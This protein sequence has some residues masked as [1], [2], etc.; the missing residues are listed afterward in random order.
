MS[1][2]HGLNTGPRRFWRA[3]V[4]PKEGDLSEWRKWVIAVV[5]GNYFPAALTILLVALRIGVAGMCAASMAS[6]SLAWSIFW[7]LFFIELQ[8]RRW[9]FVQGERGGE[10]RP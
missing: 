8:S 9:N 1:G 10:G 2:I 5:G 6:G 7:L 3:A 4:K